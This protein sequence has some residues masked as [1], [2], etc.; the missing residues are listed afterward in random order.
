MMTE[1]TYD[2]FQTVDIRAGRVLR[3]E[4]FPE[5]R[6]PALKLWIDF[7]PEI[8]EKQS[9]AQITAHYRPEQ[10]TGRQILAVVNFPPRRIAG[11]KSEVLVLGVA[12]ET[13]A[14]VLIGPDRDV[15]VGGRLH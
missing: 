3:S 9:S 11:F 12:D 4:P 15:P 8:G 5:A 14:V 6:V 1:I 13:G 2:D 7:G 10:L